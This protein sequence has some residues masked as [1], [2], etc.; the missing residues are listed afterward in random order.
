MNERLRE[1]P[2]RQPPDSPEID[3][4]STEAL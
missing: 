1:F 2:L 3:F 4:D